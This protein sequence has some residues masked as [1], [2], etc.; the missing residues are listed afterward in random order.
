MAPQ[1]SSFNLEEIDPTLGSIGAPGST[2]YFTEKMH[3][4]FM[5]FSKVLGASKDRPD[6]GTLTKAHF[7]QGTVV[8]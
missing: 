8:L 2:Q 5:S 7:I 4:L 1:K 6:D 3:P